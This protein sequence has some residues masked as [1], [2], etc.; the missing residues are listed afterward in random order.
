MRKWERD[1]T[2]AIRPL[3]WVIAGQAGNTHYILTH[4]NGAQFRTS[5]SPSDVRTI[6]NL[7]S[8]LRKLGGN[9]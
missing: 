1:L 4:A 2:R 3:G 9:Q 8:A 5:A 7:L 6:R